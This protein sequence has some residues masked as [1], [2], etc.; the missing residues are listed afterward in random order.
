MINQ[1]TKDKQLNEIE[2]LSIDEVEMSNI[3]LDVK[4][5]L[6]KYPNLIC[7]SLNGNKLT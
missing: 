5:E 4:D 7:L 3:P 1:Q 6:Q 2:E